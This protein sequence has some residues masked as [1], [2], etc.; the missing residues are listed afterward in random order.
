MAR[1]ESRRLTARG[2]VQGVGFRAFVH[3]IAVAFDINGWVRNSADGSVEISA[4]GS[5]ENM[6]S[7]I[8]QIEIGPSGSRV[9]DLEI[10]EADAAEGEGGFRVVR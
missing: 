10:R 1:S 9:D 7:F 3:Q 6:R 5:E 4:H 2:R 8:E